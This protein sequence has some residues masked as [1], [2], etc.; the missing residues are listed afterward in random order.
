MKLYAL[1][2]LVLQ[3]L[4]W[5]PTL[6]IFRLS[7]RFEV[8]GRENLKGLKQ[9]IFACNHAGELDPIVV[10]AGAAP[11]GLF[12]MFYVNAPDKEFM[13]P[14]FGW[15]RHIY[16]GW[17]FRAWG[18]YPIVRGAKDY[19]VSL[20]SHERIL[21]DGYCL[22]IFP[23]GGVSTN[24]E[25][26]EGKGGVSYLHYATGVPVVPARIRGTARERDPGLFSARK[27]ITITFGR[28]ISVAVTQNTTPSIHDLKNLTQQVMSEIKSL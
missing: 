26:R 3:T 22:T 2:P 18:S 25:I 20:A 24:G 27:H 1:A 21:N 19:A 9:A 14:F 7:G 6:L 16:G 15:R 10:T 13:H 8:R 4:A 23:E 28:P 5:I 11:T 17:F 12:P